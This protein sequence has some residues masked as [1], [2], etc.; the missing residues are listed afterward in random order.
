MDDLENI[1][2]LITSSKRTPEKT[3][4]LSIAL[5]ANVQANK[6]ADDLEA[7]NKLLV[8][9]KTFV[10][11]QQEIL[12]EKL[13][14]V[15]YKTGRLFTEAGKILAT[16]LQS[17]PE[18]EKNSYQKELVK[19]T[20]LLMLLNKNPSSLY[21]YAEVLKANT[22]QDFL[23]YSPQTVEWIYKIAH[24]YFDEKTYEKAHP[25]FMLLV[26]LNGTIFDYWL[27]LGLTQLALQ[28]I[29]EA[30]LSFYM[31]S[32]L[33]PTSACAKYNIVK[34]L[35]Q[36]EQF[37]EALDYLDE[38]QKIVTSQNLINIQPIIDSFRMLAN[39]KTPLSTVEI[40]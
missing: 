37:D 31:A 35:L 18:E 9:R 4:G 2:D 34:I 29:S 7:Q 5:Y 19:G 22:M 6:M 39:K 24:Q 40:I 26:L 27:G 21:E 12:I 25:L 16:A 1:E 13:L 11:E 14:D 20:Q 32:Q 38:L 8:P 3:L 17:I 10:E 33:D 28:K 15:T 23:S 36:L 30:L